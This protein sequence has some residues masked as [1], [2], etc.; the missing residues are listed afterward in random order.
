V[1]ASLIFLKDSRGELKHDLPR[2]PHFNLPAEPFVF[3]LDESA[4]HLVV[5]GN[6]DASVR[7]PS[8]D[9]KIGKLN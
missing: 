5:A 1:P 6:F 4:A 9:E 2:N 8:H 7:Q 3:D